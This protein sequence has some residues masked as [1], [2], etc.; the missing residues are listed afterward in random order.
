MVETY[1]GLSSQEYVDFY[2]KAPQEVLIETVGPC[3]LR[4]LG[5]PQTLKAYQEKK[6][7]PAFMEFELFHSI[8]TQT[9]QLFKPINIGL[10][11]TGEI[12]LLSDQNFDL[13]TKTAKE[14][15]PDS[16]GWDS[17]GFYTNGLKL[18]LEKRW[19][20]IRNGINWV[21]LSFDG[22]TKETYEKVRVGSHFETVYANAIALAE[23]VRGEGKNMR[24]EVIF[25]PYTE[26]EDHIQDF[27]RLWAGTGWTPSTGGSMNYGGLM[28]HAVKDRRHKYQGKVRPRFSVP[29][30]R[31]FEQ[32][33]I[34]VDGTVSYCSADPMGQGV[35]GDLKKE[36][37]K[38]VWESAV[39]RQ[40][41]ADHINGYGYALKPCKDCD[42]TEFCATPKHEFFGRNDG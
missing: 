39:R 40:V 42:Y 2:L 18:D 6:W 32:F 22:G 34:L 20:I 35:I 33:S 29:C 37:M 17:V 24:L 13:Y 26:N 25:V 30:P 27:H 23:M 7:K 28:E 11:H 1:K 4:C 38:E 8:L 3:N 21:R 14:I 19:S 15:L 36:T 5:C 31:V 12:T 10:Y 9:K 41:L 16:E